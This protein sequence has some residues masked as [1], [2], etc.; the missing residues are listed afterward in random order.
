MTNTIHTLKDQMP[1]T[2][3]G[4]DGR[5]YYRTRFTGETLSACSFG[6]GHTS[7]EYWGFVDGHAEDTFRLHAITAKQFWLD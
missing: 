2:I 1:E 6:A 4:T 3:E 7:H 5:T